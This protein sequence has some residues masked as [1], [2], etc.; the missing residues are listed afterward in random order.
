M[1]RKR[2]SECT[3]FR[4]DITLMTDSHFIIILAISCCLRISI[5]VLKH[6]N[7]IQ[8]KDFISAYYS[9]FKIHEAGKAVQEIKA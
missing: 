7:Q 9:L 2:G 8:I 1:G 6:H 5:S 4:S 3:F